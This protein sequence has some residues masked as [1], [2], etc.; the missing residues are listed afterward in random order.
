MAETHYGVNDPEAVKLWSRRLAREALKSTYVFKFL[1]EGSDNL[2]QIKPETSQGAGDRVRM[3]LRMQ[4]NGAGILGDATLEGNEEALSTYTDDLLINQ[5]RHAV[6]SAGKMSEQRIPWSVR[7]EAMTGLKDWWAERFDTT[8][9][10]QLCGNTAVTDDR[11]TGHN[12]VIAPSATRIV[13][14]TGMTTDQGTNADASKIFTLDLID[15]AVEKAKTASPLI[16]PLMINGERHY[17]LFLHTYQVTSL[18]TNTTTG[19]W[20]DIQ[21]AA[22]MGGQVSKNPIFTGALGTYNNVILHE[23][24]RV[25]TGVHSTSG[26]AQT[27]VRRAVL[28]GAQAGCLAFGKGHSAKQYAWKEKMFDYDN[29]LGVSA[30]CIFGMKKTVY[31]SVDFG[32]IVIPTYAAAA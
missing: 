32:T 6:K 21:K 15:K 29:Q 17:V 11:L 31:N 2:F 24:T 14:P 5:Q 4:L 23:S 30:G 1:G 27:S 22:M 9:F 25:T 8:F 20:Q 3:T 13:R 26:A 12:A 18:R 10:N 19:Q 28:C 7:E 16:R